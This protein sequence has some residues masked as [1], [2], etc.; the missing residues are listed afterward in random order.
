MHLHLFI[1][2]HTSSKI[3][4][5][6]MYLAICGS[7]VKTRRIRATKGASMESAQKMGVE[8]MLA[9]H[10][11][12]CFSCYDDRRRGQGCVGV[13]RLLLFVLLFFERQTLW[14]L[15]PQN[16]RCNTLH[17]TAQSHDITIRTVHWTGR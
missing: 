16:I 5:K 6:S 14:R 17:S 13:R 11:L 12:H 8:G 10:V 3:L 7:T 4:Q 2:P 1:K 9:V 15:V